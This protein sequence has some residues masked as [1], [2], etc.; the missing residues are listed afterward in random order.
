MARDLEDLILKGNGSS[1]LLEVQADK[2]VSISGVTITEGKE[3]GAPAVGGGIMNAGTLTLQQV[4]VSNNQALG[5]SVGGSAMGGGIY[6]SGT[7][8][9]EDSAIT[10]NTAQG[11]DRPTSS[12][13]DAAGGGIWSSGSLTLVGSTLNSNTAQ[14]GA[15]MFGGEALGG[16]IYDRGLGTL[17]IRSGCTLSNSTALGGTADEVGGVGGEAY[18][19]GI[20]V[21]NPALVSERGSITSGQGTI[22]N[23]TLR[24]NIA[25]GGDGHNGDDASG[26][27]IYSSEPYSLT[28]SVSQVISNT[29][30]GGDGLAHRGGRGS[31][32]GIHNHGTLVVEASALLSNTAWGGASLDESGG[33]ALGGAIRNFGTLMVEAS[34]LDNNGS[35]GGDSRDGYG[36][37]A[38]GGG[39][40]N[41]GKLT[42]GAS[43]LG[44]NSAQGGPGGAE[45]GTFDG[46]SAGGGCVVLGGSD[47]AFLNC[48]ISGN[49]AISARQGR[50]GGLAASEMT[51]VTLSF[52]TI[53][54]NE[55]SHEGGGL[56]SG[57]PT[58][59]TGPMIKNTIIGDNRAPLGP[60]MYGHVQ[61]R[62]WNLIQD[63]IDAFLNVQGAYGNTNEGNDFGPP[64]LGPLQ[65][66]GGPPTGSGEPPWTQALLAGPNPSKA[67][68]A[69][70]DTD[71]DDN[72]VG[73][74][75]RGF[76]RPYP[77]DAPG[78]KHDMGA[79]EWSGVDLVVVK[80]AGPAEARPG[81]AITYTLTFSNAGPEIATGVVLTDR[82]PLSVTVS[83]VVSASIPPD[84][85]CIT[86]TGIQ[87]GLCVA[88]AGSGAGRGWGDHHQRVA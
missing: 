86:D 29:A 21:D 82:V 42:V 80:E 53:A 81:Q 73:V 69:G 2:T 84:S 58:K 17:T 47:A 67:I 7:L 38:Y 85:G 13:G 37:L 39:I 15:G 71:I 56:Y 45:D 20:F 63:T 52:C 62:G 55:A 75:Q 61:S 78:D 10:G 3:V 77:P 76:S 59:G 65:D 19:G 50:G 72:P 26:G 1:R 27:G 16:G 14:A 60:T 79:Y 70:S 32:G 30:R 24:S 83:S 18:G 44:S 51:T 31:G 87:P 25:R 11:A 28:V 66:N 34:T 12:G 4:V 8:L 22:E 9:V 23:S 5:D 46:E 74:D 88:G 6:S 49:E 41:R 33:H 64:G 48:T 40:L 36:G 68:D 57:A 43:T 35:H 54:D